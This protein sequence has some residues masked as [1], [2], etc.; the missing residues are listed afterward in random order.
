MIRSTHSDQST[1]K[2]CFASN[3]LPFERS[4]AEAASTALNLIWDRLTPPGSE[5][6]AAARRGCEPDSFWI[7]FIFSRQK[8]KCVFDYLLVPWG[9]TGES[10]KIV[11]Q[12]EA[13]PSGDDIH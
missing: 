9:Q 8:K 1:M 2:L 5:I 7:R 13:A 3:Q 6:L 11:I 10:A 4:G 12:K